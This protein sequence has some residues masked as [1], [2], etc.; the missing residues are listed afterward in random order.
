VS[1]LPADPCRS[2]DRLR[3]Q[4]PG[5][6]SGATPSRRCVGILPSWDELR[7]PFVRAAATTPAAPIAD[8]YRWD[9]PEA[10]APTARVDF[11]GPPRARARRESM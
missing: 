5:V 2:T 3:A 9:D 4:D 8:C 1:I 11:K 7:W 6:S 10:M